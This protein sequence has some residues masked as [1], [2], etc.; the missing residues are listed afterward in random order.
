MQIHFHLE[1]GR[2]EVNNF[3]I[4]SEIIRVCSEMP[5]LDARTIAKMILIELDYDKTRSE[6]IKDGLCGGK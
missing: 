1:H 6:D 5:K 4:A 3:S 2:E